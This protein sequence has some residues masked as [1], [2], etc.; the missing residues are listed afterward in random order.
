MTSKTAD[1]PYRRIGEA[2]PYEMN[3]DGIIRTA[4]DH[5]WGPGFLM[6]PIIVKNGNSDSKK[7]PPRARYRLYSNESD[8][9]QSFKT[10][11]NM[12]KEVWGIDCEPVDEDFQEILELCAHHN[13]Q[14]Y[15][16]SGGECAGAGAD[17]T[18]I[19]VNGK[20]RY[21]QFCGEVLTKQDQNYYYHRECYRD[22]DPVYR[23]E[24]IFHGAVID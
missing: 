16:E 23:S 9:R 11:K 20:P 8:D 18:P 21:C 17:A 14:R 6:K 1:G 10:L 13:A 19:T 22:R 24:D 7:G 5:S 4:D 3:E 12:L 2:F 15:D